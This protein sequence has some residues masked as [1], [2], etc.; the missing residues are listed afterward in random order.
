MNLEIVWT[1]SLRQQEQEKQNL[2]NT[3]CIN[4]NV[5]LENYALFQLLVVPAY[6]FNNKILVTQMISILLVIVFPH[7]P[8][9]HVLVRK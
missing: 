7:V 1:V 3:S 5:P 8:Y 6:S 2:N 4:S 9:S